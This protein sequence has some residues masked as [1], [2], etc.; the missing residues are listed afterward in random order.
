MTARVGIDAEGPFGPS[1]AW[2]E[3][4]RGAPAPLAIAAAVIAI[5][6]AHGGFAPTAWGWTALPLLW[7]A[8]LLLVL[9]DRLAV[10]HGGLAFCGLL[11][12]FVGWTAVSARW[13]LSVPRTMFEVERNL[14]YVG[15]VACMLLVPLVVARRAVVAIVSGLVV[16][17]A[18]AVASYLLSAPSFDTT[19]GFL[20]FRPLGYANA[21]GALVV[22]S[23][24][25]VLVGISAPHAAVRGAAGA[26]TVVLAVALLLTHNR[27]G[28]LA[29]G[30][31]VVVWLWRTRSA[32]A[33]VVVAAPTLAAVAIVT[34]LAPD[35][36]AARRLAALAV[37][38]CAAA[39]AAVAVRAPRPRLRI[40]GIAPAGALV[41]TAAAAAS[42]TRLGDRVHYWRVAWHAFRAHPLAGGGAGTFDVE[43]FRYRDV[44]R[45]VRD[46]HNLYLGT[47]AEL[48]VVGL[49]LLVALLALPLVCARHDRDALGVALFASYCGFLVHAAFEWDWKF[50]LVTGCGLAFGSALVAAGPRVGLPVRTRA[51]AAATVL[52]PA[53]F[54]LA[55]LAGN[56][57]LAAAET[58]MASGDTGAAAGEAATARHFLP[59][60]SEPWLVLADATGRHLLLRTAVRRDPNDWTLWVRLASVE[61]GEARI[62]AAR[63]ALA[64][65]PL[66]T[67]EAASDAQQH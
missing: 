39:A 62:V 58:H 63:R 59:W 56:S 29:L 14:V 1:A 3:T 7:L 65:N 67:V 44:A 26:A 53:L 33:P 21:I 61:R 31:A 40:P 16:L 37:I 52:L 11:V 60:S 50:P 4:L 32:A 41:V 24:P 20:L 12:A 8:F 30:C 46:A 48:G 25:P 6:V 64:L 36:L 34:A 45:T 9:R 28:W 66:L 15:C 22:L 49:V 18:Y 5:G 17:V 10:T 43:W 57:R 19:Q 38:V 2:P 27:S 13:S 23:L 51:V 47:L 55:T 35:Q 42:F 54:A